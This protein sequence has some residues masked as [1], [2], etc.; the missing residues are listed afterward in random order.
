MLNRLCQNVRRFLEKM[1]LS[2]LD[3]LGRVPIRF[4]LLVVATTDGKMPA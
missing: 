1:A 3:L 2:G 4:G